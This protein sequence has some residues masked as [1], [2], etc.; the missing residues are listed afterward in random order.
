MHL[1]TILLAAALSATTALAGASTA[2]AATGHGCQVNGMAA[3]CPAALAIPAPSDLIGTDVGAAAVDDLRFVAAGNFLRCRD[4]TIKGILTSAGGPAYPVGGTGPLGY[5]PGASFTGPGG[6]RC[7]GSLGA[8]AVTAT[9]T[10]IDGNGAL[11][12]LVDVQGEWVPFANSARL[13]LRAPVFAIR[14]YVG[15][16][17]VASC[18]YRGGAFTGAVT[19]NALGR[20]TFGA[21]PVNRVAGPAA[22]PAAA[23]I[24]VPF[25]VRW[26]AGGFS[27]PFRIS[28]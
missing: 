5:S 13:T 24:S 11:P 18:T 1:K 7:T 10:L 19:N 28:A 27:G 20:V 9:V 21:Q 14:Q 6:T 2:Q 3:G 23:T 8:A 15:A 17:L 22:C 26:A 12:G 25:N 4:T 16:A